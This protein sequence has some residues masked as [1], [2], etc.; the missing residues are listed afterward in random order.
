MS[1]LKFKHNFAVPSTQRDEDFHDMPK[2]K[3][4]NAIHK[5]GFLP[6]RDVYPE[7]CRREYQSMKSLHPNSHYATNSQQIL[8]ELHATNARNRVNKAYN[9]YN[10][11]MKI[12]ERLTKVKSTIPSLEKC[13]KENTKRGKTLQRLSQFQRNR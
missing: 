7:T 11:N 8:P 13:M 12:Y 9:L 6:K 3:V 1:E 4:I 5:Y 2:K 10:D